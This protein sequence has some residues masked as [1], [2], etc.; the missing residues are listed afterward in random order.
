MADGRVKEGWNAETRVSSQNGER[1]LVTHGAEEHK[2]RKGS[3]AGQHSGH[4]VHAHRERRAGEMERRGE[5][6]RKTT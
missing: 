1:E 3:G 4:D 5:K 6:E 2:H